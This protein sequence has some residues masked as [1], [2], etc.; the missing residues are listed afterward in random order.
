MGQSE[1]KDLLSSIRNTTSKTPQKYLK[2]IE[3]QIDAIAL[4]DTNGVYVGFNNAFAHLFGFE[5]E[6]IASLTLINLF[7]MSFDPP[8][9]DQ[10]DIFETIKQRFQTAISRGESNYQWKYKNLDDDP[11]DVYVWI[12]PVHLK[13]GLYYQAILRTVIDFDTKYSK[14]ELLIAKPEISIREIAMFCLEEAVKITKSTMGYAYM[15]DKKQEKLSSICWSAN[16]M[17]NCKML[18]KTL[19]YNVEETGL[20]GEA[21]RQRKP[22]I[23]N[24][25]SKPNPLKKGYPVGHVPIIRS[26]NVPIF[27][28]EKKKRIVL[29]VGFANKEEPYTDK[30]SE[31]V[32]KIMGEFWKVAKS[33]FKF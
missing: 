5:D 10:N 8:F 2:I 14:I 7:S 17:K 33:Q 30:D 31:N 12:N 11:L 18:T 20:W 23:D 13:D 28:N 6:E 19:V 32:A 29:L 15:M 25:Y 21:A 16:A 3:N 26:L 27:N 1:S 4:L 9:K 24:D 22:I